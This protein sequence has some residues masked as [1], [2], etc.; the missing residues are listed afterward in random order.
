MQFKRF[1]KISETYK[2]FNNRKLKCRSC[3][4]FNHYKKVIQSEG[5]ALDPVFMIIGECPGATEVE[6]ERPFIGK[7]GQELRKHLREI[8]FNRSNTII[9][10]LMP[11]RPKNNIFPS[12]HLANKCGNMWLSQE[13]GILKPKFIITCGYNASKYFM[14][15][16]D[17]KISDIRGIIRSFHGSAW[18]ATYHPSYVIRCKNDKSKSYVE[19][20]FHDDLEKA[21]N[22]AH[23]MYIS[24]EKK[25]INDY[26]NTIKKEFLIKGPVTSTNEYTNMPSFTFETEGTG[27]VGN[28][29]IWLQ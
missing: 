28:S 19:K 6:Q 14:G 4:V 12:T 5:N 11:C 15:L 13:I 18:M 2:D 27:V 8:G 25:E 29:Q 23:L 21:F 17:E 3:I 1:Y 7:S 9:T 16:I 26:F 10:N 24:K 22:S 20:E